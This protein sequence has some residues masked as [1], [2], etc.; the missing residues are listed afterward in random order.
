M[1]HGVLWRIP[2]ILLSLAV[3]APAAWTLFDH[4]FIERNP[5]HDHL[6]ASTAHNHIYDTDYELHNHDESGPIGADTFFAE[7]SGLV[8]MASSL[9]GF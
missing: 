4:H 8:A 9:C 5:D 1:I 7:E 3:L 2:A 6:V